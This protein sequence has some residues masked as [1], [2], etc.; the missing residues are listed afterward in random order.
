MKPTLGLVPYTGVMAIEATFDHVGPMTSN[1]RDN[2]LMLEVMAGADGL[3]PRQAAPKVDSYSDYLERG[4]SGLKIGILLEGFQL[5]NQDPR[6]AEKVRGAIA[7]FEELGA[8]VEEVSVPEHNLAGSLWSPIGCEGLTMQMMHGNG[9]GFNWKG[10]Y[11]VRLL[12]KQA[13]WRNQADALSPSLKLC[14][15]VGQF[16]LERYNGRYYAKAQN[17]ARV[18]RAGYDKALHTYDLLVMPT[19]P[20]IAQPLPEPG[21]SITENVS[22]ALE[23]LGNT[24]AQDI[25]GHPA[26]SIPC[27]LVDGLPVG[28]MLV[29]KHYAE[30][31]LYQAA[32]A[33]EASVDWQTL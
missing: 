30:G 1:V 19:V 29:G 22:R 21:C 4:V 25:T 18:A 31:T 24:A 6:V 17:I 14:M 28:L 11:D 20:I 33:F 2:A 15:F 32:A 13:G 9:A 7:K 10:L 8:V 27:G 23:M 3:D 26:M 12:D 16:G 5:A